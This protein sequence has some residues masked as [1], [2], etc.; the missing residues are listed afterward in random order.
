[1]LSGKRFFTA[2]SDIQFLSAGILILIPDYVAYITTGQKLAGILT[3][4]QI[5]EYRL[6]GYHL[7]EENL[8]HVYISKENINDY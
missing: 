6:I 8:P 3:A 7:C 1:M 4:R 2:H 5:K